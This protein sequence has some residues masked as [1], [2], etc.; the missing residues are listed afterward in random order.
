[1]H[2]IE[3]DILILERSGPGTEHRMGRDHFS[4]RILPEGFSRLSLDAREVHHEPIIRD[5]W[6]ETLYR[7]H[8]MTNAH[9]EYNHIPEFHGFFRSDFGGSRSDDDCESFSFKIA[10]PELSKLGSSAD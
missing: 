5:Q 6:D 7:A 4:A 1:M 2:R 8:R 3:S 10:F 9:G